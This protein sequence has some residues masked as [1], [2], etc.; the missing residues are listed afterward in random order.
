M[1]HLLAA[2]CGLALFAAPAAAQPAPLQQ[3]A[4][5]IPQLR[6][7]ALAAGLSDPEKLEACEKPILRACDDDYARCYDRL[8]A[9]W[10]GLLNA[11]FREM[12]RA[13]VLERSDARALQAAQRAW[14][15]FRDEDCDFY[16][17]VWPGSRPPGQRAACRHRETRE[18]AAVLTVRLEAARKLRPS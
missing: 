15:K 11:S 4:Q 6:A 2:L 17:G 3:P 7:C 5:D 18:R 14:M 12:T 16:A 1:K 10:D 13:G 8:L 9:G